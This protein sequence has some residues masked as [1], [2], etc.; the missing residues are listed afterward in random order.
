MSNDRLKIAIIGIGPRGLSVLER[1]ISNIAENKLE[2]DIEIC[3]VD[4][5]SFGAGKVWRTDQSKCLLMNTVASQI[6]LFTD[7][8]VD[9][10]GPINDGPSLYDWAR[11]ITFFSSEKDYDRTIFEEAKRL[12]PDS[13]PTRA[14]YGCYLKWVFN[15]VIENAPTNVKISLYNT[16]A[17]SL[18]ENNEGKQVLLLENEVNPLIID[19]VI[20]ALGHVDIK[21]SKEENDL[22]HFAN[23]NNLIYIPTNNPADVDLNS[24]NKNEPV[25][26]RGLGLNFFDYMALFTV[27]RGGAFTRENGK[28]KY[29]KSGNEPKLYA[30]SRRGIPYHARGENEKGVAIRHNPLFIT[31]EVI[32][33]FRK[34]VDNGQKINFY[35]EIWPLVAKEVETVYYAT[36]LKADQCDCTAERFI[37]EYKN[38]FGNSEEERSILKA[39]AIEEADYWNWDKLLFPYKNLTFNNQDEYNEWLIDYLKND[40]IEAKKG[41]V[42]G[43]LKAALDVMRDLRNE[44]RLLV[45]HGGVIGDS[46]ENHVKKWYTPINAFLSIGPPASRIEEMIALLESGVLELLGPDLKVE[47]TENSKFSAYS[48]V[49]PDE[50]IEVNALVEARLPEFDLLKSKDPLLAYLLKTNQ[51]KPFTILNTDGT[52]YVT[53][54]VTVTEPPNKLVNSNGTPNPNR[55]VFGIPT[56]GVHWVTAAGIRPGVNSVTL[57]ES[58]A[59]ARSC[60]GLS[61]KVDNLELISK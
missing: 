44:V 29:K 47:K 55:F 52:E 53:G 37:N 14:F 59:I 41:N 27:G 46:Y 7:S 45:N 4:P 35:D 28:L 43:P 9:C 50:K 60:L 16:K 36:M 57:M 40:L 25:L 23:K 21:E 39:Y 5:Y 31:E 1:L 22:I 58:D 26:L 3:V 61:T 38:A 34:K 17:V 6:T 49:L 15:Y 12:E 42:S 10:S 30:G 48:T 33:N 2:Q 56:E 13:Y 18:D 24:I 32:E 54:G 11:L 51:C 19:K 8:S 20:L